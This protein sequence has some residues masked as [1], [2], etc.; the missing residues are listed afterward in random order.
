MSIAVSTSGASSLPLVDLSRDDAANTI[1]PAR[2]DDPSLDTLET[3]A[4]TPD[5]TGTVTREELLARSPARDFI[6]RVPIG[7]ARR[8]LVC[9]FE[10]EEGVLDV[11]CIEGTPVTILDVVGRFLKCDARPC[12]LSGPCETEESRREAMLSVIGAM[13]QQRAGGVA[14]A[15]ESVKTEGTA[16]THVERVENEDL[17][18]QADRAPV[19]NLV[20]TLLAEAIRLEASDIH[21]QPYEEFL[22]VRLRVDGV[23]EDLV[24]IPKPRQ[25]EVISR[26]KVMARLDIAE[27]RLPQDGRVAVQIGDRVVD[28][29]VASLPTAHGERVVVRLLDR[30]GRLFSLAELG[31]D[32]GTAR[33]LRRFIR[34]DHGI[35]LVTG[36][37]GSG[38][39]T[40]LYAAL[41]ELNSLDTNI[42]TLE[43][44]IEYQLAGVSQIQVSEKK[45]LTFASGLRSVLRQDPDIIMVGEVRDQET[46]MMAVQSALTGHLVFSTLHTN[47]AASTLT[48]LLDLGI[49]PYLVASSLVGVVAQRLVRR[50][51]PS[52]GRGESDGT[53]GH[54][55]CPTC[56]G[57]GYKG[58]IGLFETLTVDDE[59]RRCIDRR[60]SAEDIR[61]SAV[62][63]GMRTLKE[64]G[65]LRV[66]E[67][68]TT[69]Q[70]VRR[71]TLDAEHDEENC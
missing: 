32:D 47:D 19:V 64:C 41:Q 58:R 62:A 2:C 39:T 52:C 71:A 34:T 30:D 43:D 29:R 38:K 25:E 26:V 65:T 27:K 55:R 37:T 35:V 44:P 51:C 17:L 10:R 11:A 61:K 22:S 68:V 57:L 56:R 50:I 40:T 21:I 36:P 63:R 31:M 69:V 7:F 67:G 23:L 46:A 12:F 6:E 16:K 33:T 24:R 9:G 59:I 48:R 66:A 42:I 15:L 28:M 8:H 18:D 45:G 1:D 54:P 70:E 5:Q 14:G 53:P 13:Y 4:Q 49:E 60:T 20:N 3:Q